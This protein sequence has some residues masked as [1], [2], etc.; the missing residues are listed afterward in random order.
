[1]AKAGK[2]PEAG[3]FQSEGQIIHSK[4]ANCFR[5]APGSVVPS[6]NAATHPAQQS[7]AHQGCMLGWVRIRL[8]PNSAHNVG[9]SWSARP[10]PHSNP[11]PTLF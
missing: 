4:G 2:Q 6:G 7:Q 1:M 10:Q 3:P 11:E 5:A 8:T 9:N